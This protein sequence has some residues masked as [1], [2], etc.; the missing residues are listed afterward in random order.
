MTMGMETSD[1][2]NSFERKWNEEYGSDPSEDLRLDDKDEEE[3]VDDEEG[4]EVEA[5]G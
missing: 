1:D 2:D 4:G 3:K 5:Q